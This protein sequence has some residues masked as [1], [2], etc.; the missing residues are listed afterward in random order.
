MAVAV[1]GVGVGGMGTAAHLNAL[2]LAVDWGVGVKVAGE[3]VVVATGRVEE[4]VAGPAGWEGPGWVG[5]GGGGVGGG[6]V[7]AAAHRAPRGRQEGTPAGQAAQRATTRPAVPCTCRDRAG[8]AEALQ[9][10]AGGVLTS[11]AA[12]GTGCGPGGT[13]G[14]GAGR[15]PAQRAP[16]GG[17]RTLR[18]WSRCRCCCGG[19]GGSASCGFECAG[20]GAGGGEGARRGGAARRL[21]A[22]GRAGGRCCCGRGERARL[23]L[24]RSSRA[25][26]DSCAR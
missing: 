14:S 16:G 7:S 12:V 19:G 4:Q 11:P 2:A 1:V 24:T 26:A 25:P 17:A 23:H 8:A 21:A 22:H 15:T 10:A 3:A 18:P 20:R 13:A 5:G 9:P 6:G